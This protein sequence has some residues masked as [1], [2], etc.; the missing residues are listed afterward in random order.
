M[1]ELGSK[2]RWKYELRFNDSDEAILTRDVSVD[3]RSS[4]FVSACSLASRT[5][6]TLSKED[7]RN[8]GLGKE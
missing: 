8:F 5:A 2:I 6:G 4:G 7:L 1:I 3:Y